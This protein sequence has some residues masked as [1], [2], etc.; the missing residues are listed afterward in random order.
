M[1][2]RMRLHDDELYKCTNLKWG[3]NGLFQYTIDNEKG[4]VVVQ[5]VEAL[6]Y[7]PEG[8]VFDFR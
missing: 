8:C 6:R 4:R 3:V 7:N 1:W 2:C 5:L